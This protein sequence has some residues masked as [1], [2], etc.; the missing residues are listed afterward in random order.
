MVVCLGG[1]GGR[2]GLPS[3]RNPA[4]AALP[5]ALATVQEAKDRG[6]ALQVAH[7]RKIE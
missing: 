6:A 5:A 3:A 1:R 7:K 4:P 2:A